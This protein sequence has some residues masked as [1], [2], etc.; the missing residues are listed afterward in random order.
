M[1]KAVRPLGRNSRNDPCTT[2]NKQIQRLIAP[3]SQ[4]WIPVFWTAY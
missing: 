3:Q 1:A 4:Q 2:G